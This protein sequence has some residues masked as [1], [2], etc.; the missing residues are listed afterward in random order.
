MK[1]NSAMIVKIPLIHSTKMNLKD[2]MLRNKE[3]RD[4]F[5]SLGCA[6]VTYLREMQDK[7]KNFYQLSMIQPKNYLYIFGLCNYKG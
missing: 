2:N 3:T 1:Y 4:T 7:N 6:I 5:V